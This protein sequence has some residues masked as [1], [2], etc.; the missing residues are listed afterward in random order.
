MLVYSRYLTRAITDGVGNK[1]EDDVTV[2]DFGLEKDEG[3][4]IKIEDIAV[5]R[6]CYSR[7]HAKGGNT[8]NLLSHLKTHHP[9]LHGL[10]CSAMKSK[11][12]EQQHSS[13]FDEQPTIT[14]ALKKVQKYDRQTKKWRDITNAVTFCLAKDSLAINTVEKLGFRNLLEKLDP[15]YDLPSSKYFSKIAIPALY[16]ETRQKIVF[17]LKEVG[18][19][20]AT[21]DMWSSITGE[22][23]LSYTVHYIS[24]EWKLESKCLQ[25]LYFPVDHTAENI[26]ETLQDTLEQWGLESKN[27]SCITTDNGSNI[28]CAVRSHLVWPYISCFGHNLHLAINNSIKEDA[29]VQRALGVCRKI[30]TTFAHSWKKKRDLSL[31]QATLDLP[32]HSLVGDCVTRWGSQQKMVERI[33]EQEP[34]IRQVLGPDR[35]CSHLIPT[36]QDIEVLQSIHTVLSP[37]ADF[38]D[39][40]SGEERVTASAIKPLLNV[41]RNKVLVASLTDTTLVA[42]IK[43]R[44]CNYLESKYFGH[45]DFEDTINIASFFDP[46]FKAHHLNNEELPLIKQRVVTE[47]VEIMGSGGINEDGED[48]QPSETDSSEGGAPQTKRRKLSSWLREATQVVSTASTSVSSVTPQTA[49]QKMN[50]EV[51]DYLKHTVIDPETNPLK[52]WSAHDADFPVI[53]KLARKYL[54]ICASSSPSERVFSVSGHI[55]SKKRNALKPDKV[56]MLVFLAKN[57]QKVA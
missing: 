40:L 19:F 46:R 39:M 30:V 49:E 12:K 35:R 15:Q 54:C 26:A 28:L 33:L 18:F 3:G 52:W 24:H 57:L 37:L 38:T 14:S 31:A 13:S 10:V 7:V 43:E 27:Q 23:Y 6:K 48:I 32:Q 51:E 17:D 44:I 50:N 11:K 20:S 21:T 25:T 42:D 41:L 22:P 2:L 9:T 29:R 16:E 8:S 34:A 47:G 4:R 53:S 5:C 45:A 56:N 1:E 36:W 55:V